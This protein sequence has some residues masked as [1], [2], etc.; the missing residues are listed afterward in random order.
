MIDFGKGGNGGFIV[1]KNLSIERNE[2]P[3]SGILPELVETE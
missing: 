3:L 1:R 2:V